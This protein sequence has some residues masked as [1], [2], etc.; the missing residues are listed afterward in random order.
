MLAMLNSFHE[1]ADAFRVCVDGL[2]VAYCYLT[3]VF[4]GIVG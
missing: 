1:W 3:Y 4:G 2:H